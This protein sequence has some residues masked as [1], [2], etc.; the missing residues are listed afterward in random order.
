MVML[1]DQRSPLMGLTCLR[2]NAIIPV[3][4][5]ILQFIDAKFKL[6]LGKKKTLLESINNIIIMRIQLI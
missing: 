1:T 4:N 5:L 3:Y 6:R 2:Y